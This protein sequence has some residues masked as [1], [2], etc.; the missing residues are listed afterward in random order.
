M[1]LVIERS[2][3]W[4]RIVLGL[5]QALLEIAAEQLAFLAL[6]AELLLEALLTLGGLAAKL[7]ERGT[8]VV[9]GPRRGRGLV[10]DDGAELGG[11]REAGLAGRAPD[12]ER[13]VRHGV[14]LGAGPQRRQAVRQCRRW[15][16]SPTSFPGPEAGTTAFRNVGGATS[17]TT[18][19]R[20]ADG[21][22]PRPGTSAVSTSSSSSRRARC[23]PGEPFTTRSSWRCTRSPTATSCRSSRSSPTWTSGSAR[24]DARR[25][26][27]ATVTIPRRSRCS[28]TSTPST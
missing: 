22:C 24:S 26:P 15:P 23:G 21:T 14:K 11:E 18:T 10:R 25:R 2:L 4:A 16:I 17:T 3:G 28:S 12:G 19:A 8:Q 13:R 1:L 6:G 9:D 20:G 7:V 5:L 27:R